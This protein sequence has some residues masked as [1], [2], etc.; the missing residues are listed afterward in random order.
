MLAIYINNKKDYL[1]QR[2][3]NKNVEYNTTTFYIQS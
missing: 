2:D 3:C 1:L